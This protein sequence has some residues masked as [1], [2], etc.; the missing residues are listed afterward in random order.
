[1]YNVG[2]SHNSNVCPLRT[3][4][5]LYD[6][7]RIGKMQVSG[8]D[9]E[10]HVPSCLCR[11]TD[12]SALFL[13][14]HGV[15]LCVSAH[16]PQLL[17]KKSL[18][19]LLK[20]SGSTPG[21]INWVYFLDTVEHCSYWRDGETN[22][23]MKTYQCQHPHLCSNFSSSPHHLVLEDPISSQKP[24]HA[25]GCSTSSQHF[26]QE[27]KKIIICK[28]MSEIGA[29]VTVLLFIVRWLNTHIHSR[30]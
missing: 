3:F 6:L 15:W 10:G 9:W 13:Q 5:T 24:Q 2:Y 18:H 14:E 7:L 1:M 22:D 20:I 29:K 28:L 25:L 4:N 16:V 21:Y 8:A 19:P 12:S 17:S 27:K 11:N 23:L 30:L 26:L